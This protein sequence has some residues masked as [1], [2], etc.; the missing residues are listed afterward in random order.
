MRLLRIF[1]GTA[2]HTAGGRILARVPQ[3]Y[4]RVLGVVVA[5]PGKVEL[6]LTLEKIG[7]VMQRVEFAAKEKDMELEQRAPHRLSHALAGDE[8][9]GVVRSLTGEPQAVKVFIQVE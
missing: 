8:V 5:S 3:R 6:S 2:K 1:S 9:R 4:T 7:A